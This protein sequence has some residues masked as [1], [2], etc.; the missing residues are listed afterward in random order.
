MNGAQSPY[1]RT[2]HEPPVR[3]G[4]APNP[5]PTN[6]P[7]P[8]SRDWVASPGE[9]SGTV[10]ARP[11]PRSWDEASA[12]AGYPTSRFTAPSAW[13]A[14][15]PAPSWGAGRGLLTP[16]PPPP[17][18]TRT[19]W[20]LA[21]LV[22]VVIGAV[23]VASVVTAPLAG[24]ARP[25]ASAPASVAP[26]TATASPSSRADRTLMSNRLYEQ[27]LSGRCP[28]QTSP[29]SDG[30]YRAQVAA[31]LDCLE[32]AYRA[33]LE[34]AGYD[35]S[36]VEVVHYAD[37]VTTSC[38][39]ENDAY[40]FYCEADETIFFSGEVYKAAGDDR[41]AL[42]D[43]VI[44]EYGHHVQAMTGILA[45][46][47]EWA[48]DNEVSR[49]TELQTFCWTYYTFT[50]LDGF[51]LTNRDRSVFSAVWSYA[52]DPTGHGSVEAQERWGP[53]GL[54]GAD[55]GACNTWNVT[56]DEVD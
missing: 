35:V 15:P 53:R 34:A 17:N 50:A 36:P 38:G 44:H 19:A 42:A 8:W 24:P 45:A 9:P 21:L 37:T 47:Y 48:G 51:E 2:G 41:L 3:W 4:V 28:A 11:A 22:F 52:E 16:P 33:P 25:R 20:G 40:A 56:P 27:K 6:Q 39:R 29:T 12:S 5:A 43:V 55:L 7:P 23:W 13:P 54:N 49:R 46:G 1:P 14:A 18:N 31:L 30:E 32:T 26:P 10:G